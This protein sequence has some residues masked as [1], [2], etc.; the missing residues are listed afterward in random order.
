MSEMMKVNTTLKTLNLRCDK[1][2]KE[3]RKKK[4]KK[5]KMTDNGIGD[6]GAKSM[7]EMLKVNKTLT[8]L[9]L[10]GDL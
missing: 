2:R 10:R 1:E 9:N 7:S 8:E 5:K 3:N 4:R 6:E